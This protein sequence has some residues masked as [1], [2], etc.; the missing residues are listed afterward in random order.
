M[1]SVKLLTRASSPHGAPIMMIE[2]RGEITN[3]HERGM[4]MAIFQVYFDD[5][6]PSDVVQLNPDGDSEQGVDC[7]LDELNLSK[8]GWIAAR[9]LGREL[10]RLLA[11]EH[12]RMINEQRAEQEQHT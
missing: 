8:K 7:G 12:T 3:D 5:G 4:T 11:G 2:G 9:A 10:N 6:N 1:T